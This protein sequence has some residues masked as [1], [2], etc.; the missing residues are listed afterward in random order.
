MDKFLNMKEPTKEIIREFIEKI[1]I[2]SDKK[3]DIHFNFKEIQE[4][5]EE[6][7]NFICARKKIERKAV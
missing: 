3:I 2:H 6:L 4:I 5:S 1:E 7:N